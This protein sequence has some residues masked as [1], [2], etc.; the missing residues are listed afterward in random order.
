MKSTDPFAALAALRDSLPEGESEP[1]SADEENAPA[2]QGARGVCRLFYERKG[3][4]GKEATIVECPDGMTDA[5][6]AALAATLKKQLGTGGS[7]RDG[8]IL[9]QGDRRPQLRKALAAMGYTVK[10]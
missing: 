2:H 1:A 8:E 9:L 3:R 6:V 4:G 5:D 10:G 7:A